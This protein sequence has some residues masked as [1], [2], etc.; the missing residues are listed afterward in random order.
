MVPKIWLPAEI[1]LDSSR[2]SAFARASSR[3]NGTH[4]ACP[5]ADRWL[6]DASLSSPPL[7]TI[8]SRQFARVSGARENHT[9]LNPHAFDRRH[10]FTLGRNRRI[11]LRARPPIARHECR[12]RRLSN[13]CEPRTGGN[14]LT[15]GP[16]QQL[17]RQRCIRWW[18]QPPNVSLLRWPC[19]PA[20]GTIDRSFCHV[21]TRSNPC[22]Q[23]QMRQ[24]CSNPRF[25]CTASGGRRHY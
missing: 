10:R 16:P 6:A 7:F 13:G 19:S 25:F 24:I 9:A 14:D 3:P 12:R 11:V 15:F 5:R 18:W 22:R 23:Q 8:R 1:R 20:V 21:R 17:H 4:L 2:L